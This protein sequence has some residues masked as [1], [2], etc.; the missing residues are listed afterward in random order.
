MNFILGTNS[1][2]TKLQIH[3]LVIFNQTTK[4]YTHEEK[5][6]HSIIFTLF[7]ASSIFLWMIF[8]ILVISKPS[9]EVFFITSWNLKLLEEKMWFWFLAFDRLGIMVFNATFNNISVISLRSF[10]LV[11]ETR[12]PEVNHRPAASHL[13]T[14]SHNVVSNTPRHERGSNSQR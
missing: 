9:S 7:K 14:L 2:S 6:F 3:E 1:K 11:D 13:Q 8:C 4:M 12:V 5:C 10:L